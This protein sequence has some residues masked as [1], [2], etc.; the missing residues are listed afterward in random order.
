MGVPL[1]IWPL[2][3]PFLNTQTMKAFVLCA[4]VALVSAEEAAEAPATVAAP[5]VYGGFPFYHHAPLTYVHQPVQYKYVPKEY[6]VEVKSFQ[7]ELVQ[8]GCVNSFGTPGPC[9]AKRSADEAEAEQTEVKIE[10]PYYYAPTIYGAHVAAAP[11]TY[12]H[13][14]AALYLFDGC[15]RGKAKPMRD[16]GD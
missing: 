4:L 7:P 15:C 3:F 11:L 16:A 12:T 9:R 14:V 10:A 6:E 1:S 13:H 8:T 5:L 2:V